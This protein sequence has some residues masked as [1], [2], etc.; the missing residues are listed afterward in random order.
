MDD[1]KWTALRCAQS[2]RHNVIAIILGNETLKKEKGIHEALLIATESGCPSI[3][4]DLLNRGA[5]LDAAKNEHGET[6]FQIA[7]KYPKLRK[8]EFIKHSEVEKEKSQKTKGVT[9]V[10]FEGGRSQI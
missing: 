2:Q 1:D 10:S 7:T 8:E 3:L 5:I 4:A 6:V 9:S